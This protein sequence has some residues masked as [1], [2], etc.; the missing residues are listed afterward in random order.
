MTSDKYT[1]FTKE[2]GF[3]AIAES[4][5]SL[6]A[7]ILLPIL[8]KFLGATF[9]GVWSQIIATVSV[10]SAV[11]MFGFGS[12]IIRY[13][14]G[15]TEKKKISGLF[16]SAISLPAFTGFFLSVLLFILAEPV[17]L[18]ILKDISVAYFIKLSSFLIL[19]ISI[20]HLIYAYFAAVR[21]IKYR[22][23]L[24]LAQSLSEIILIFYLVFHG[25]GLFGVIA[26]S[27]FVKSAISVVG[28]T[29]IRSQIKFSLPRLSLVKQHL[30]FGGPLVAV[31]IF[32]WIINS[33]DIYI[34][35][36]FHGA[37]SIGVYSAVYALSKIM[38]VFIS[39][40]SLILFPAVFKAIDNKNLIEAKTYLSYS[41]KY[42]LL[43]AIPTTFGLCV[44]S[45]PI[46]T[47]ITTSEFVYGGFL[48][49]FLATGLLISKA[50]VG[51]VV[52][53][54]AS[55]KTKIIGRILFAV[56][57]INIALNLLLVPSFGLRGAAISTIITYILCTLGL[58]FYSMKCF[59][60]SLNL[61]FIFKCIVA[62]S[63]MT[64]VLFMLEINSL[65]MLVLS[66]LLGG[67]VYFGVIL[68]LRCISKDEIKLFKS[69]LQYRN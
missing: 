68:L 47:L 30:K 3:V 32:S 44:L 58:L 69:L 5:L 21:Q 49:P 42:F 40:I 43:F 6:Q 55:N 52:V 14:A 39:P 2:V 61:K 20:N 25:Y 12:S 62:S 18:F 66:I 23:Y 11:A 36:F 17:A 15:E 4:L 48:F 26:V 34:I 46:L 22:T 54:Q 60:F 28:L 8:A 31:P 37:A 33:S 53:L 7:F 38:F 45:K 59:R 10:L 57:A 51:F 63:I 9:Y 67:V 19:V 13:L 24:L 1:K 65:R 27:L 29:I 56:A 64:A 50:N 35:G 41:L 16:F